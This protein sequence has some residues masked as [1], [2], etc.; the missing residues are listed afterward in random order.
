MTPSQIV[1]GVCLRRYMYG[2]P[3][4]QIS[5][6]CGLPY[7]TILSVIKGEP[8]TLEVAARL[9]GYLRTPARIAEKVYDRNPDGDI[10]K[11]RKHLLKRI[12]RAMALGITLGYH[13]RKVHRQLSF[14]EGELRA[15]CY[16]IEDG[17]R[18]EILKLYPVISRLYKFADDMEPWEYVERLEELRASP[19][20]RDAVAHFYKKEEKEGI[21]RQARL[22]T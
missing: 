3:I 20:V 21:R 11:D 18:R 10:G 4:Q 7:H 6:E 9:E 16:N 5:D 1:R 12:R 22:R 13:Y 2:K 17:V 8:F 19:K 15:Y 14:S